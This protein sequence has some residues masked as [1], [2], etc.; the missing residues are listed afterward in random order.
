MSSYS[1]LIKNFEKIRDYMR[2]FYVYGFKS[3][4]EYDSKSGRSYD[5]ERRRVESW[6]GD[7]MRFNSDVE[8]KRVFL[9]VDSRKVPANPLYNAFKAKS[10]TSGDIAFH[11]YILDLLSIGKAYS[12]SE[13]M[14]RLTDDYFAHFEGDA[15]L[16]ESSVRKKL[17]EY[18]KLGV[19]KTEKRGKEL[20]YSR[21]ESAV[22]LESFK[23]A[24]SF[25]SEES[26]LGVV[27]SFILDKYPDIPDCFRHKHH[28]ILHA[29]DSGVLYTIL[30]AM[31]DGRNLELTTRSLRKG[32]EHQ[33]KVFPVKIFVSTQT[34]R[35]YLLC[36]NLKFFKLM[37][38]RLDSIMSAK[39][40]ELE[41]NAEKYRQSC[42]RIKDHLWGVSLG[43]GR[44]VHRIEM[45]VHVEENE[46][47]IANRLYREKRCGSVTQLDRNTYLYTAE[48]Y[49]ATE[50]LPW[51]R[52]F[53]GRVQSLTC[54]DDSVVKTFYSDLEEMKSLYGGD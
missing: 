17:R 28:Y 23:D 37:F 25:F 6:L 16:D 53:I 41:E 43:E 34:G 22:N 54:T 3:R 39:I 49:D 36:I 13:I 7:Y 26:P 35:Q 32:K 12:V 30:D 4:S 29:L 11:F 50:L 18:V 2:E 20:I 52:T 19:L 48:V 27:G 24:V 44:R 33:N 40:T 51:I 8:G 9:S 1:E 31:A 10:F 15:C 5:N 46:G 47:Y 42:L 38:V 45:T 21:N 14:D